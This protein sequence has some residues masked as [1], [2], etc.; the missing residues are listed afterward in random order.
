[1]RNQINKKVFD[2]EIKLCVLL[3]KKNKG[4]C[5]WGKCKDC[6]VIPFLYKLYKG[7]L[8]EKP[9]EIKKAKSKVTKK[10]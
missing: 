1:M 9:A 6:G 8:L 7:L 5:N 2:R 10:I 3:S 4:R